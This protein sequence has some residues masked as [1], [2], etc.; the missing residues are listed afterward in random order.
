[1]RIRAATQ[2]GYAGIRAVNIAA[3]RRY[4]EADLIEALRADGRCPAR[5]CCH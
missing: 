4:K 3:F 5:V 2:K 1:M